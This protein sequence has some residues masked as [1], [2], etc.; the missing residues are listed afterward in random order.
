MLDYITSNLLLPIGG[1]GISLFTGWKAWAIIKKEL[2]FSPPTAFAME[3]MCKLIAPILI[4]F[5]LIY[6]I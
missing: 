6:N 3:W 4:G 2:E 5:I 1:I